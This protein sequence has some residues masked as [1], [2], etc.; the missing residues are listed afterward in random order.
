MDKT[1]F[2]LDYLTVMIIG[3]TGVGKSCLLNNL[4]YNR[5]EKARECYGKKGTKELKPYQS[6]TVPYL[7]LVD[8]VGIELNPAFHVDFVG[9]VTT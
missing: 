2:K 8:T 5:E 1:L 3:Q 4:L 6:K 9:D 7:R